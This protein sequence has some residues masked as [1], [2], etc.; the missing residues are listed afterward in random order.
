MSLV[1]FKIFSNDYK[2]LIKYTFSKFT[3]EVK[4]DGVAGI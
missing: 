4:L 2:D 3:D 1:L